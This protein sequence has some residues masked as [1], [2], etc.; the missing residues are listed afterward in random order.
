MD[1]K[2]G[3]PVLRFRIDLSPTCSIGPGKID[4]LEAIQS[5]G[6]LRAAARKLGYSYRR[7]WHL[8][9]DLNANLRKPVTQAKFGGHGGG[10][11]TLTDAGEQ[12]IQCYRSTGEKIEPLVIST[13]GAIAKKAA[14]RGPKNKLAPRKRIARRIA[15]M[16][17]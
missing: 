11:V 3:K 17:H 4:L 5:T 9:N 15:T 2:A 7:A 14:L 8:L 12:L 6:T 16:D 10:G 13:L 1:K